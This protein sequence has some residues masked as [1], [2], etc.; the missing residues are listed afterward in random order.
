[1]NPGT[2]SH[3]YTYTT[4]AL[5]LGAQCVAPIVEVRNTL[6]EPLTVF[7]VSRAPIPDA[8]LA[9]RGDRLEQF[10]PNVVLVL[11]GQSGLIAGLLP[12][13]DPLL[14]VLQVTSE[15]IG[16]TAFVFNFTAEKGYFFTRALQPCIFQSN[17]G[18]ST[19][20]L[21]QAPPSLLN[22]QGARRSLWSTAIIFAVRAVKIPLTASLPCLVVGV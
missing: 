1:M 13:A 20:D 12:S 16:A 2:Y 15:A 18:A 22:A 6:T 5:Q 3:G 14:S 19:I 8:A 4:D 11:P 7:W 17:E 21:L 10:L 9:A